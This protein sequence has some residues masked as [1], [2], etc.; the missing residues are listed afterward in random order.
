M[1][2]LAF[3]FLA[4]LIGNIALAQSSAE[5]A[6]SGKVLLDNGQPAAGANV[7][8]NSVGL[9]KNRRSESVQCDETGSFKLTG[10]AAGSYSLEIS[11]PGYVADDVSSQRVYRPG[12]TVTIH[13]VKGGVI[14]G[15][16]TDSTGEPLVY[17][18]VKLQRLRDLNGNR[19]RNGDTSFF[20]D[21]FRTTGAFIAPSVCCRECTLLRRIQN[22]P[23][24]G[25]AAI[26]KSRLFILRPH[27]TRLRNLPFAPATNFQA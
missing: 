24:L 7:E 1:K 6:L 18:R 20:G 25:W 3:L 17:A 9:R 2:L 12:E 14:T 21:D 26:P 22:R 19:V 15:K 11:A 10:L 5:T 13:L 23:S 16:V 27:A 8:I 4:M